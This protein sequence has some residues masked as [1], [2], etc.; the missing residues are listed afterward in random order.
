MICELSVLLGLLD[1]VGATEHVICAKS[2]QI[3]FVNVKEGRLITK[4]LA[5]FDIKPVAGKPIVFMH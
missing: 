3:N 1:V 4:L 5:E 2:M